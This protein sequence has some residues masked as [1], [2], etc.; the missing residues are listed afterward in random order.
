[1]I[2]CAEW[3]LIGTTLF[4]GA[5]ALLVPWVSELV[6]RRAFAP[7][8]RVAFRQ[9]PPL[10]R[11]SSWRFPKSPSREEPVYAFHREI[12]NKG[13]SQARRVE[14]VLEE[15]W[16]YDAAGKPRKFKD[17]LSVNLRCGGPG[18]RFVDLN[19]RRKILWNL[20][21]ISSLA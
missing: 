9:E 14:V 4:P 3:V 10:C 8:I 5:I 16:V 1:M 17:F 19:P 15:I 18:T 7:D 13:K 2:T 21:H 12:E 6:K 11:L 20:G